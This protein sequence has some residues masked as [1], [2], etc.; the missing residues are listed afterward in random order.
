MFDPQI[1]SNSVVL[2]L[3]IL[4][5]IYAL[6][7]VLAFAGPWK[8]MK[9]LIMRSPAN[10]I[11]IPACAIS[12]YAIVELFQV[13]YGGVAGEEP[14]GLKT[15]LFEISGPAGPAMLWVVCF[16]ALIWSMKTV[17]SIKS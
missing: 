15:P 14:M 1:L 2:M 12:A 10:N 9:E 8:T 17:A 3:L 16:V 5:A 11:G 7:L 6:A 13:R 4:V